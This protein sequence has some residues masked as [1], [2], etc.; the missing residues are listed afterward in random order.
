[1]NLTQIY[2]PAANA[3]VVAASVRADGK[4]DPERV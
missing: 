4:F 3:H 1:M 2:P